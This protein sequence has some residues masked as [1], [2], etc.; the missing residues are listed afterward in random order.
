MRLDRLNSMEEYVLNCGNV[1][2]G[3]LA[4]HFQISINT[5]RRDLE[6]L[7][8]RGRIKKVYGG[9]TS[10]AA[11]EITYREGMNTTA[12]QTIGSLTAQLIKDGSTVFIDTGT[13]TAQVVPYLSNKQNITIISN[14]LK[15]LY[16]TSKYPNINLLA[17]GGY[18]NPSRASF[19]GSTTIESMAKLNFDLVLIGATCVSLK[20][21]LTIN[22]HFEVDIKRWLV[23]N[24][25]SHIALMADSDKF[26][27][28]ALYS[29]CDFNDVNIIVSERPL[30]QHYIER[31]TE[32]GTTFLCPDC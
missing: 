22:N 15:V 26:D 31:M 19:V 16:E 24:N 13:T 14:S 20:S 25:K 30:P 23:K 6:E 4:E 18:Y 2:L 12:K 29:F 7:L 9:V 32:N 28:S 1:S 27:K 11:T 21:G 3:D 10:C 5:V 17:I 8:E